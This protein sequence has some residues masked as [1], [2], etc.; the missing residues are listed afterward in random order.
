MRKFIFTNKFIY[1]VK[2]DRIIRKFTHSSLEGVTFSTSNEAE[3]IVHIEDQPDL[4]FTDQKKLDII[5]AIQYIYYGHAKKNIKIWKVEGN[6]KKLCTTEADLNFGINI[7]PS[8][9]QRDTS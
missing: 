6:L 3:M 5:E 4:H 9:N 2:K 1:V 7:I 8:E